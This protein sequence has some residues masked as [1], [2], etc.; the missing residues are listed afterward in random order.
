MVL[1][2]T[3]PVFHSINKL[4]KHSS[5][6]LFLGGALQDC[7]VLRAGLGLPLDRD[8]PTNLATDFQ[9]HPCNQL[10]SING[11]IVPSTVPVIQFRSQ[12]YQN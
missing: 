8:I 10:L 3:G 4:S 2:T 7:G 5:L 6:Y 11:L 12:K 9:L 1:K